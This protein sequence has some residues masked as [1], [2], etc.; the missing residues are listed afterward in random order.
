MKRMQDLVSHY[1]G[2]P[3]IGSAG[4]IAWQMLIPKMQ[5]P[6]QFA[7]FDSRAIGQRHGGARR[8]QPDPQ[9][10]ARI[11]VNSQTP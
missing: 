8:T 6:D 3:E 1:A 11:V 10:T 4:L 2:P 7:D 9:N 5:G